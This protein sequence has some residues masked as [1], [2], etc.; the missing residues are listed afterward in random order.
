MM[1]G[2][3]AGLSGPRTHATSDRSFPHELAQPS[4]EQGTPG[5]ADFEGVQQA[6]LYESARTGYARRTKRRLSR[7]AIE[8]YLVPPN[9]PASPSRIYV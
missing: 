1:A 2:R 8:E 4:G 9:E 3:Q 5:E 6:E 7:G